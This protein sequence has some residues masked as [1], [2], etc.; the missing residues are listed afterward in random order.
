[1]ISNVFLVYSTVFTGNASMFTWVGAP[2]KQAQYSFTQWRWSVLQAAAKTVSILSVSSLLKICLCTLIWPSAHHS[3][4]VSLASFFPQ[5]SSPL[6][7]C[8]QTVPLSRSC[9]IESRWVMIPSDPSRPQLLLVPK[10]TW[11][12]AAAVTVL[13]GRP[14]CDFSVC[15]CVCVR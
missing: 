1:M 11:A 15:V 8:A 12:F 14:C 9:L 10:R 7:V 4:T 2:C 6:C 13:C 3:V 5:M